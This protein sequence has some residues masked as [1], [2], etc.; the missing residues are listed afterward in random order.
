MS[1]YDVSGWTKVKTTCRVSSWRYPTPDCRDPVGSF[2][3]PSGTELLAEDPDAE[4]IVTVTDDG[5]RTFGLLYPEEFEV[6][7]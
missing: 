7:P 4:A 5:G 6:L 1:A 2:D 3:A